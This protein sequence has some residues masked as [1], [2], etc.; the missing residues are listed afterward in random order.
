M[1]AKPVA[2]GYTAKTHVEAWIR[3][4]SGVIYEGAGSAVQT[5]PHIE[6]R[7]GITYLYFRPAPP[8]LSA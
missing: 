2:R 7:M 4:R 6:S 8:K 3:N 5:G 1:Y